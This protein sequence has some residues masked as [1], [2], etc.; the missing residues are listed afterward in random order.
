MFSEAFC[1]AVEGIEG[2]IVRVE[3]DVSDGLPGFS[4]V[5]YLSSEVKEAKERVWI[6]LR[7]SGFRLPPKKITVNLSPADLRK[8]GTGYD[9]AIAVAVLSAYG[10]IP[11]EYLKNKIFIGELSL[12]G[13]LKPVNG[14]LPMVYT[15]SKNEFKLCM[16]PHDNLKEAAVVRGIDIIAVNGL[17]DIC[18]IIMN[19]ATENSSISK[20][21][22]Y[23]NNDNNE[24]LDFVD[25][26]GQLHVKRAIEV[27]VSGMHNLLMIGPPGSGKSMLA[28]RIPGIMPEPEFDELMEISKIYSVC[29]LLSQDN[30]IIER[31][32]FRE[33]H[34]T[35]TQ[36]A[37]VGGGRFPK[38]GEVSLASGGVLFLDEL[39]E[40][41]RQSIEVLRQPIE[42]G[43][44]NVSRLGGSYKYPSN[45]ELIAAMNPCPC[46][47]YPD[48]KKCHC[49][50]HVVQRYLQKVSRPMLDRIDICTET[51]LLSYEEMSGNNKQYSGQNVK[52]TSRTIRDR[53]KSVHK[54]Q[55]ERYKNES[56]S[57]NSDITQRYIKKYCKLTNEAKEL[58]KVV[59]D[60]DSLSARGYHK[61]LKVGR[62]IA[63][64]DESD[65]ITEA[66]IAEAVGYRSIDKKYWSGGGVA[67]G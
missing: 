40:F 8:D 24:V 42:D 1:T 26:N 67:N 2:R 36:T 61:I 46:G 58:L 52:D 10:Y 64:M 59:F 17:K 60:M 66:H 49:P 29:G 65:V 51:L 4:L 41:S 37:L 19:P 20:N 22:S 13:E 39:P 12:D 48:R 9:L 53:V 47:F 32:P 21:K 44:V 54:I 55:K 45:F 6:A 25:V 57:F 16:L 31:R 14:V 27:A 7:N 35:I 15:A 62:T 56:F 43:Y 38:P 63:D 23:Q 30:P 5:G 18:N 3:A 11:E 33:P 34:H 50:E 28:K